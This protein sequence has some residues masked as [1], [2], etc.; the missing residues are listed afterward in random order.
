MALPENLPLADRWR[1]ALAEL[2]IRDR[3][4]FLDAEPALNDGR[5]LLRFKTALHAR[6]SVERV[7]LLLPLVAT[8][9][10]TA[11]EIEILLADK[12]LLVTPLPRVSKAAAPAP[13][14]PVAPPSV[15]PT[16][17]TTAPTPEPKAELVPPTTRASW[18]PDL[19]PAVKVV[20]GKFGGS[21]VAVSRSSD[22]PELPGEF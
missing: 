15:R 5:L 21:I 13:R 14:P 2:P 22:A 16:T 12:S 19:D 1:R 4:W 9:I 18:R 10:G 7:A 11:H 17:T 20:L 6:S 3:A 8:W